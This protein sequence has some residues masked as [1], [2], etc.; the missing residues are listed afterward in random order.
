MSAFTFIQ[1]SRIGRSCF[2]LRGD[3]IE[4]SWLSGAQGG[5]TF[6]LRSISSDYDRGL[7]RFPVLFLFPGLV[8]AVALGAS[9]LLL[10]QDVVPHDF[11]TYPGMFLIAGVVG[12]IRGVPRVEYFQFYDHWRRPLFYFVR[13]AGQAEECDDFVRAFLDQIER[14]QRGEPAPAASPPP[15]ISSVHLP[16]AH[17]A[18]FVGEIRWQIS[19]VLGGLSAGLPFIPQFD[20]ALGGLLFFIIFG[21]SVGGLVSTWIPYQGKERYR[22]LSLIGAILSLVAPF[23]Y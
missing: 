7:R 12:V 17:D 6:A 14:V 4:V 3:Q 23:C 9:A 20:A 5:K 2:Q 13:E 22:H 1:D 10:A 21:A 19:L 18:Y 11:V 16:S 15:P 8:A